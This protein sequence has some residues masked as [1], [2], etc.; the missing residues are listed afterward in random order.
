MSFIKSTKYKK[1]NRK[2]DIHF[3]VYIYVVVQAELSS[4]SISKIP[5][6]KK[7]VS[8]IKG[9]SSDTRQ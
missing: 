2:E 4:K 9:Y 6:K 3:F 5:Y 7:I 1:K 8:K